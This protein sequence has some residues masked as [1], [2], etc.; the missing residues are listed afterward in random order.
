MTERS[1]R[2]E[3]I[4]TAITMLDDA[5]KLLKQ[6]HPDDYDRDEGTVR[7]IRDYVEGARSLIV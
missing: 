4:A 1:T 2:A 6:K 5:L 3:D 7:E